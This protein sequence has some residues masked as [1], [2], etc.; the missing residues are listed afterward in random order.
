MCK[1]LRRRPKK[2]H[3]TPSLPTQTLRLIFVKKAGNVGTF[4]GF[5]FFYTTTVA[6]KLTAHPMV[7]KTVTYGCLRLHKNIKHVADPL[8]IWGLFVSRAKDKFRSYLPLKHCASSETLATL[9]TTR[10]TTPTE[11]VMMLL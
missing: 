3:E 4:D 10:N 8:L 1:N 2:I 5:S 7:S 9:L 6:N 11:Q